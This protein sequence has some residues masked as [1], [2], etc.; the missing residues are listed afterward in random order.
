MARLSPGDLTGWR[1]AAAYY[2]QM[3]PA[4]LPLHT[5]PLPSGAML[6]QLARISMRGPTATLAT[7]RLAVDSLRQFVDRR[8]YSNEA[9]GLFSPWAFH[10]DFGPDIR[11]GAMFAFVSAMSAYFRGIVIAE[12]G[13]GK[14]FAAVRSLIEQAG[15]EIRTGTK[16]T[17]VEIRNGQAVGVKLERGETITAA[18]TVI[19]N[20]A[21]LRLF[22][23]LVPSE[24]VPSGFLRRITQFRHAVGTFVV[25][26]ALSARL[27]WRAAADLSEFNYVHLNGTP[28]DIEQTYTQAL[29]GQIPARPM[30]IVSQTSQVD[31]SRAPAGSHVAR[32]HARAFPAKILGDAAGAIETRDWDSIKEAVADRIIAGLAEHAPNL[33]SILLARHIVSPLDLERSNPNLIGGDCNGGS[34]HLDQYYLSRPMFGWTRY[35]TPIQHLYMIGASQWPGSGVNGISGYL[36][37]K[38]LLA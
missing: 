19:A 31:P 8:F 24:H 30:L 17:A 3:A 34:H 1:G 29:R 18:K 38:R 27:Q 5:M 37:A 32:I 11:G 14:L 6:R 36:L 4:F 21:P 33:N 22:G 20:V 2:S 26:L 28:E 13:A 16:V 12:G 9:K 35:A 15:G 25:H 7:A 10:L 23:N